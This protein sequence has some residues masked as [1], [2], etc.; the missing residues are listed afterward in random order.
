MTIRLKFNLNIDPEIQ[1]FC[2]PI[3]IFN[4]LSLVKIVVENLSFD[5]SLFLKIMKD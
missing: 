4:I 1:A 5:F 2:A 3:V